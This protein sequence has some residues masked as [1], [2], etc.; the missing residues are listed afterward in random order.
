M[1]TSPAAIDVNPSVLVTSRSAVGVT[2]VVSVAVLSAGAVSVT[3]NGASIEAV[4]AI[5]PLAE[6]ATVAFTVNVADPPGNSDTEVLMAL[7]EPEAAHEEPAEAAQVHDTP[8]N[9][10]GATS[11]NG[12]ATTA[13][14]PALVTTMR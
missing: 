2:E 9:D 11:V 5:T 1:S 8:T 13:D 14:G 10:A 3:P 4:L 12:A 7:P 6:P